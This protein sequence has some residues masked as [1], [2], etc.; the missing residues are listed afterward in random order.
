M[1]IE[2]IK[3][4]YNWYYYIESKCC[5]CGEKIWIDKNNYLKNCTNLYY[6]CST[7]CGYDYYNKKEKLK[8]KDKETQ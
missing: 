8:E 5:N 2:Y 6:T 1:V 7:S 3:Q 4:L